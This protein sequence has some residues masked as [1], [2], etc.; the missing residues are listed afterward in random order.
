MQGHFLSCSNCIDKFPESVLLAYDYCPESET[1]VGPS[2]CTVTS[3]VLQFARCSRFLGKQD[4]WLKLHA[5]Y[6]L[7]YQSSKTLHVASRNCR[8]LIAIE[9][10]TIQA[11]QCLV[12]HALRHSGANALWLTFGL[13][14]LILHRQKCILDLFCHDG[15]KH[16]LKSCFW[17][18]SDSVMSISRQLDMFEDCPTIWTNISYDY[19]GS[20][21]KAYLGEGLQRMNVYKYIYRLIC[22]YLY[23]Y[24][25]KHYMTWIN[26]FLRYSML[27]N[28]Q[29]F[30]EIVFLCICALYGYFGPVHE[31]YTFN[32][33]KFG[34]LGRVQALRALSI[35]ILGNLGL[36]SVHG[37][38]TRNFK[39]LPKCTGPR[40]PR[41]M[42]KNPAPAQDS[43]K[44]RDFLGNYQARPWQSS[45]K[46][47]EP[48]GGPV[49]CTLSVGFL[50][51]TE[52]VHESCPLLLKAFRDFGFIQVLFH[53]NTGLETE[54]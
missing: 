5:L 29:P 31:F 46:S 47:W 40:F 35:R 1:K 32:F 54:K 26:A 53:S 43:Q 21:P 38:Y 14:D 18:S 25:Y 13:R 27:L 28:R 7:S 16:P 44:S 20:A 36:V 50:G 11:S 3:Q 33:K 10:W 23:K 15:R 24:M 52:P 6:S 48:W 51:N 49:L 4:L 30:P 19:I 42:R 39:S 2:C 45:K 12:L 22:I 9:A 17:Q 41:I 8:W 34:N 37:F